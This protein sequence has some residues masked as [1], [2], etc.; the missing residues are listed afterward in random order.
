MAAVARAQK[1]AE[2]GLTAFHVFFCIVVVWN[3]SP[4]DKI[5][6]ISSSSNKSS[7]KVF[8]TVR[9]IAKHFRVPKAAQDHLAALERK[10]VCAA[11]RSG[12]G[13]GSPARVGHGHPSGYPYWARARRDALEAIADV[14]DHLAVDEAMAKRG[15]L[16]FAG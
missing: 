11:C 4:I 13:V 8:P 16:C 9:E 12:R 1:R 3:P 6:S 10:G 2:K 7:P 14:E 5:K 15:Q